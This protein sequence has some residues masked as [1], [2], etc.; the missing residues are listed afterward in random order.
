MSALMGHD[1]TNRGANAAQR[2]LAPRMRTALI[3]LVALA[4]TV[5]LSACGAKVDTVVNLDDGPKGTRVITLT[6]SSSDLTSYVTG[7]TAALDASLKRHKPAQLEYNGIKPSADGVVATFTVSFGSADEYR[8]K[9]AAILSASGSTT[10]PDI[11]IATENT[12]FVRG[13]V[14]HENF[15]SIDLLGWL[16]DGLVTDGVVTADNK[17][18][19]LETGSST[20]VHAGVSTDAGS[21]VSFDA[22]QDTGIT[23]LSTRTTVHKDGSYRR[24]IDYS[25][26][27]H[28]YATNTSGFDSFFKDATPPGGTL[29]PATDRS[30][31]TVGWTIT[32][33]AKNADQVAKLTAHAVNSD[34]SAFGVTTEPA[35]DNAAVL[36]TTITDN[37]DCSAICSP[38]AGPV[39]DTLLAPAGWQLISGADVGQATEKDGLAV[40]HQANGDP[41]V[42][43]HAIPFQSVKVASV[44]GSDHS[45]DQTLTFVATNE[46]VRLAGHAFT[47]MLKPVTGVGTLTTT[48]KGATTRYV[49]HIHA[50]NPA[51]YDAKISKYV[52]GAGV[53]VTEG[54]GNGF[55]QADYTVSETLDLA[56]TLARNGVTAGIL[57]STTVPFAQHVVTERSSLGQGGSADGRLAVWTS[58]TG[59][60]VAVAGL[61][62]SALVFWAVVAFVLL[63]AVGVSFALRRR[64]AAA[65]AQRRGERQRRAAAA[66]AVA[67]AEPVGATAW[68]EGTP[69][70]PLVGEHGA[71]AHEFTEADLL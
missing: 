19:V 30:A 45:V 61:P 24:E 51:Q 13:A 55:F 37:V 41:V 47:T 5:I 11:D 63:V 65:I 4:S 20:V 46:N 38:I 33:D 23:A 60:S 1:G 6:L 35:P 59:V 27:A 29:K 7:G 54:E 21:P 42:L 53:R 64:I 69:P 9:I 8:Q 50:D 67:A 62:V 25:M 18:S 52:P 3:A 70:L 26:Q 22:M 44:L 14:L 10:T 31:G 2:H 32:F 66:P 17:S 36:I 68:T 58:G 48:K 34:R 56:S 49:V 57:Y 40:T 28:S 16:P 71:T 39:T 15:T 43:Q 12:L